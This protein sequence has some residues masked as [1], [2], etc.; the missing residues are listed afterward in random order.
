MTEVDQA[1][2]GDD[3]M[4]AALKPFQHLFRF[5]QVGRLA[6]EPRAQINQCVGAKNQRVRNPFRHGAGLAVG[7]ELTQF[8]RGQLFVVRFRSV[9]GHD[10]K[11]QP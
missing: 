4:G 11:S 2:T 8:A 6:K 1:D 3:L 9:A 7:V 10:M 5:R